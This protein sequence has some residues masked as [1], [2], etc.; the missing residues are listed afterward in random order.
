MHR[1]ARARPTRSR[2]AQNGSAVPTNSTRTSTSIGSPARRSWI[3]RRDVGTPG[4]ANS[5]ARTNI[6]PTFTELRHE[7]AVPSPNEPVTVFVQASDPQ[8][9]A[10]ATLWYAVNDGD[11]QSLPLQAT[12]TGDWTATIPGQSAGDVVQFYV[13]ASDSLAAAAAFPAGGRQ[14]RAL[15][16]VQDQQARDGIHNFRIVMTPQDTARLHERTN[17]M[18]NGRLGAT[19]IYNESEVFYDV[20]VRLKGSNAGRSNAPYLGFNVS[21][22]PMHLFRGVHDSVAI[23]RSGRSSPTPLTQDEI[24]IKHIAN[25]AGDI[26]YM[27]D[28]LVHVIAPNPVHS[29]TALLMMAR[30]GN[31]FLDSQFENGSDGTTFRLD[32]AYVPDGT[33]DGNPESPKL[34]FPYSHP[35]PTKDLEDLGDDKELYRSHVL[36]RNNRARDDYHADNRGGTS[37]QPAG[38]RAGSRP[39]PTSLTSTNG[40]AS[41]RCSP[42]QVRRTSTRA[43][44]CTTISNSTCVPAT[45][46]C[47]PCPGIGTLPLP[48]RPNNR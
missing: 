22:D 46:A 38:R 36:I 3:D 26:P 40:R 9:V 10:T 1:C 8:G 27:Y 31:E 24:L 34:P 12:A 45:I 44:A 20:G 33:T 17:V 25:H 7:P 32:I 28:D 48:R 42:C 15:F 23:D 11:F 30:Y 18:S 19:V 5:T 21:F 29:R 13:E 39:R 43:A 2:F 35:Q 41:L 37:A 4:Q 14:S 6:G 47:W 16:R